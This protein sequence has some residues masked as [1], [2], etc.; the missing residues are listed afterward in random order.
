MSSAASFY[1]L[2][3]EKKNG[4]FLNFADYEGKVVLVQNTAT[5][6][7]FT[8]QLDGLEKLHQKYKDQGLVVIGFPCNQFGSQNKEDDEGTE[9]FCK[10]NYGV[11]F[12]LADKSDVNGPNTNE[13]FAYLKPR[14]KGLLGERINWNF[15][16][17]LIDRKGNVLHRYAPTTA[18]ASIEKDIEKA[19][20]E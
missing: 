17:F 14:A 6:C 11:T 16:K 5:K 4:Q 12:P 9:S 10:L 20:A 1:D 15:T 3:A 2:K 19:L 18:P 13:V 7:G 8:P